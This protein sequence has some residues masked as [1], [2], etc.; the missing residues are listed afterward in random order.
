[1]KVKTEA[2][3]EKCGIISNDKENEAQ[4]ETVETNPNIYE[5]AKIPKI[6]AKVTCKA[7]DQAMRQE[8][9][10]SLLSYL[11]EHEVDISM[12]G[13]GKCIKKSLDAND[14]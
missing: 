4:T 2:S 14:Q 11:E 1:M 13:F 3:G 7:Q 12:S 6:L 5:L 9:I 10:T 8:I